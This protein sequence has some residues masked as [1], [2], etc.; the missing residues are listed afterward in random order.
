MYAA[1][2]SFCLLRLTGMSIE[3]S[4]VTIPFLTAVMCLQFTINDAW[5]LTKKYGSV[6]AAAFASI[7]VLAILDSW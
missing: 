1:S 3:L 7:N 6:A 4:S 5:H 2:V